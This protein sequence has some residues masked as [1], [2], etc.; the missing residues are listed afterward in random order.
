LLLLLLLTLLGPWNLALHRWLH[1]LLLLLLLALLCQEVLQRHMRRRALRLQ[2]LLPVCLS[3]LF[4]HD[5][6]RDRVPELGQ[7]LLHKHLR[8]LLRIEGGNSVAACLTALLHLLLLRHLLLLLLLLLG[9]LRW[10]LNLG[11]LSS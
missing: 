3:L 7:H 4:T 9:R 8:M 5:R 11:L 1:G 2:H 10:P 6:F